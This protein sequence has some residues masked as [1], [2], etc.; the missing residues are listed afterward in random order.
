MALV[1]PT[2]RPLTPIDEPFLWEMLYQ[3]IYIPQGQAAPSRN[4][5][6]QPEIARYVQGWGKPG[7]RGFLALHA[8]TNQP[9]GAIWVRVFP[10]EAPG[11]GYVDDQTPELAMAVLPG[12]R[13]QGVGTQLLTMMIESSSNESICLSV[14]EGNPVVRLY[15]RFGFAIVSQTNG[16]ITMK[17]G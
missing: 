9:I 16:S 11:Y 3:A 2:I 1:I 7:D 5:I 17:R 4:I 10:I 15:R 6:Q 12:D 14:S 8:I 13:G